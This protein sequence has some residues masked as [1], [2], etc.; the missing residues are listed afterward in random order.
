[1]AIPTR[2]LRNA[3]VAVALGAA[4][5]LTACGG[6]DPPL[7][8][9]EFTDRV[10]AECEALKQASDDFREAQNPDAEGAEVTRFLGRASDR[11]RDLV[12]NLEGLVPP[13]VIADDVDELKGLLGDYADGLEEIGS[14]VGS[15]Q[16]LQ[17]ALNE[18]SAL[19]E[20]LNRYATEVFDVVARLGLTGCVLET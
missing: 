14:N 19:V 7:S 18:S 3:G 2:R 5:V 6:S 8:R 9:A 1:M 13:D 12:D 4:V 16:T 20:R 15:R 11:L 17:N 10:N